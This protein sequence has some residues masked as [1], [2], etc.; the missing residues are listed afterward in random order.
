MH[1]ASTGLI[2]LAL[3]G[4]IC[5]AVLLG[6]I[7]NSTSTRTNTADMSAS[8]ITRTA[9]AE[10]SVALVNR[11]SIDA[12]AGVRAGES[13]GYTPY[14]RRTPLRRT[15]SVTIER[16][17]RTVEGPTVLVRHSYTTELV[18]TDADRA[19]AA[20][21]AFVSDHAFHPNARKSPPKPDVFKMRNASEGLPQPGV[22]KLR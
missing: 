21:E 11:E 8:Q 22:F 4:G 15:D 9:V 12:V 16:F 18:V 2:A 20:A 7:A 3:V 14:A 10:S 17:L 1:L 5:P 6:L 19:E 13:I